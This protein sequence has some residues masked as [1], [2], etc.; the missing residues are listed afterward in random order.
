MV[1]PILA[2]PITSGQFGFS[3]AALMSGTKRFASSR[4][5]LFDLHVGIA[6]ADY[7]FSPILTCLH[8]KLLRP[9]R[10]ATRLVTGHLIFIDLAHLRLSTNYS[11]NIITVE[12]PPKTIIQQIQNHR[13]SEGGNSCRRYRRYICWLNISDCRWSVERSYPSNIRNHR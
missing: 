4:I 7:L 9:I 2:G 13:M 8:N 12:Y 1:S 3:R 10:G 6:I 5:G 11:P